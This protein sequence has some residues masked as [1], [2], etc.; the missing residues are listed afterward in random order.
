MFSF[1]VLFA[2]N[3]VDVLT[4]LIFLNYFYLISVRAFCHS[5]TVIHI[6]QYI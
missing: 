3:N 2:V 4:F 6:F 1:D 5:S